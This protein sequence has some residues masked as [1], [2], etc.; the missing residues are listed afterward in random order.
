LPLTRI[1]LALEGRL[2]KRTERERS[3]MF[4]WYL[5]AMISC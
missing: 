3:I 5:E 1:S 2:A 4:F